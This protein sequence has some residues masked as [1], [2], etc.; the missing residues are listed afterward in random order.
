[1][2]MKM[3]NLLPKRSQNSNKG[4]FG[5]V[6]NVSGSE[7]YSGAGILSSVAA[8]K[9]GAG[10]VILCSTPNTLDV[11]SGS[12]PELVLQNRQNIS[13]EG[14]TSVIT[15]CGLSQSDEAKEV[16]QK[17]VSQ[18]LPMV[19]DADGLNILSNGEYK[20]SENVILTPHPKEMS[21]LIGVSLDEV[22]DNPEKVLEQCVEKYNAVVVLKMH[23]TLVMDINKTLYK[24]TTGNSALAKAGSGDVL[25]GMMGGFLA[26]G[27]N[28]FE[29]A[30]LS[31]YL[32]GLAGELASEDLTEYSVLAGD[33]LNYIPYAIK[34]ILY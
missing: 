15:G 24:N 27:M 17:T 9:V 10:K 13:F 34:K 7:M 19:I 32:H 25:A 6:L 4:S 22:L 18:N 21:R 5:T 11:A 3:I 29:C 31:V 16:F 8:L 14:V 1:M 28:C 12:Y 33:L 20:L 2:V 26:Q 23:E 30:K